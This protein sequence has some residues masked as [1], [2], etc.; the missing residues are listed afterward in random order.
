M[1]GYYARWGFP[2]ET[3]FQNKADDAAKYLNDIRN[4]M[5][6]NYL[7]KYFGGGYPGIANINISASKMYNVTLST[8]GV[9]GASIKINTVTPGLASGSWTGKYYSGNPITVTAGVPSG[10][11][12]DGWTVTG[13]T[14]VS[15]LALTTAV[16]FTEDVQIT[17]KYRLK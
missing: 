5:V 10:Y 17:A 4:A 16:N 2:W 13:G 12:F 1:D 14:A 6:S 7:P 11:E 8:A 15:P 9:S 3:V